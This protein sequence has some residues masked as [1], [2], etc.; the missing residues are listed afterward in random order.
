MKIRAIVVSALV[1]CSIFA[2]I[3]CIRAAQP[4]NQGRMITEAIKSENVPLL[5]KGLINKI[6]TQLEVNDDSFPSLI[7]EVET[8]TAGIQDPASVAVLHSMIAEMYNRFYS[9]DPW[10]I[11]QRTPI[12]GYIPEDIREW[13]KNLFTDKIKEELTASLQPAGLLQQTPASAFKEIL[14]SGKSSPTLRPTLFDF[15]AFRALNIQPSDTIYNELLSFRNSQPDKKAALLVD[16]D[17]LQYQFY[18]QPQAFPQSQYMH[19]LDSLLNVYGDKDYAVEILEA[20][21]NLLQQSNSRFSNPDSIKAIEYAI[22]T[23][24]I[25]RYPRYDRIG[26]LKNGL[27]ELQNPTL[28]V[29]A[30]QN[31]YPGGNLTLA[32]KYQNSSKITVS[33]YK[34]LNTTTQVLTIKAPEGNKSTLGALVKEFTFSLPLP[35]A[36]TTQDTTLQI[37]MESL[38]LYECVI[39]AHN[40]KIHTS[41][42]FSVSRLATLSR[43]M[44]S[45]NIEILVTDVQS[46]KPIDDASIVYYGG[47][48]PNQQKLGT[49]KTDK[50]GLAVLPPQKNMIAYKVTK[51]RDTFSILS[52]VFP[53]GTARPGPDDK[54]KVS[55]FTDRGIYRP[56]QTVFFKGIAYINEEDNPHVVE[57]KAYTVSLQD[58]NGQEVAK[59]QLTTNAFGSFNGEFTIPRQTLSGSFTIK[60]KGANA[61]IQVEE[62]KRPTFQVELLPLK[63][64]VTFGDLVTI[65]GKAQTFSGVALQTGNVTYRIVR[66]PFWFRM[67]AGP[68]SREQVAEGNT[69]VNQHGLFSFDFRPEKETGRG[70]FSSYQNYQVIATLTDSKG[71]TQEARYSFSVGEASII[72]STDLQPRMDKDSVNAIVTARTLNN[73]SVSVNGNYMIYTLLDTKK[74]G[75]YKEGNL[76]ANGTFTSGE[77]INQSIFSQLPSGRYR[78]KLEAKDTK[79]RLAKNEQDFILYS[80]RDKRPPVFSHTWFLQDRITCQPGEEAE[81]MFGT[82][83]KK[84]YILYELFANNECVSRKRIELSD[85]NRTFRVPFL[86]S[87]GNGVVASFIFVKE[88][89][90]YR[91][92]IHILKQQPDRTLTI[93]PETFRDRLLPGSSE[94]WKFRITKADSIPA[95]AEVLA[96]MYDAS[97][98]QILPFKWYFSPF[99]TIYLR[100]PSFSNNAGFNTSDQ[101]DALEADFVKV[102][103]YQYDRLIFLISNALN[104]NVQGIAASGRNGNFWIRGLATMRSKAA[105]AL[106]TDENVVMEESLV[107]SQDKTMSSAPAGSVKRVQQA[108]EGLNNTQDTRQQLRENF[109]ETAFFFPSLLTD[110]EGS[111]SI[112]FTLPESNTTWKFQ[113]LAHTADLKYGMLTKDII[114]SKP[115]MVLPNL[116]RFMRQGDEVSISTQVINQSKNTLTGRVSLELFDPAT[117]QPVICLTKSQ[118]PFTLATDST[119]TVYWTFT[120]PASIDLI[121]CRII[122]TSDNGSDGEQLLIPVLSNKILVTE[123]TPFYLMEQGEQKIQIPGNTASATRTPFSMTLELTSNP[124]WYAVQALPTLTEPENQNIISWF[125]SYYSNTLANHIATANPRIQKVISQWKAQGGTASTLYSNL[126]KNEELKNILLQETPWVLEANN[127]TEQKER[128]SLLFDLNRA[129]QQR[130]AA[131]QQLL[132]QQNEDGGWSWFKGLP[133]NR[134]MTLYILKGMTQLV[135][136]NAIQYGQKEKEMQIKALNYLDKQ[137]QQEYENVKKYDKNWQNSSITSSQLEYLFVRSSYRDIPELGS[138]REAIRFYTAKAEKQWDKQSL[139]GK[140]ETALLMFRNGKKEV[141]NSI[142]A[143]LRKTVT[144][145]TEKGMYWANNRKE[146]NFFTS[147]I[148][149]HCLLMAVFNE[150]AP[151]Q[152]EADR[153]KQWLLNQKRTQ[154]WESVPSTVNAI[155]ALLLTGSDW[156]SQNNTCIVQWGGQTFNSNSGEAA[157][158]Y[159]KEVVR[160]KE[161]TPEMSTITVR[162]EGNAPAWGAVYN[163]Y[164]ESITQVTG[165]KGVL[166]VEKKLFV[167][168]NNGTEQQIRPVTA[169]QPLRIGDKVIVRL[170][171]RSEQEMDYVYLKDLRAGCFEQAN[172][173]SGSTYNGGLWY[174]QSPEDVSENFFFSRLPQGTFVLEYPVYVSRQGEYAGGISTIQCLYAPEFVSHTEGHKLIVQP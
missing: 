115:L 11:D 47:Q 133:G 70:D 82:S 169:G 90:S 152:K 75:E 147:P 153:M 99:P 65:Q 28:S 24:G 174:Y 2:A 144:V 103:E 148:D 156:L 16:L 164:F 127:E 48:Y 130:E 64:E 93:K 60:T 145:S 83:D 163:Q 53:R 149:T 10:K 120:V 43:N 170:T 85:E 55:L 126:Q 74:E 72:L 14:Q 118:K 108:E 13:S 151:N 61:Y 172:Q 96:S 91:T 18:H 146:S 154:N 17:Y 12:I 71:E 100:A 155:Y 39:T 77:A 26:L 46:G 111:V 54:T 105:G 3:L 142:L 23:E 62:Y 165:Q 119:T 132:Q 87:Y 56:G 21:L 113:A 68:Q 33:I 107:V 73:E 136:L 7:K 45:G 6:Q 125:A 143:W 36:Y 89:K 27:A 137:I 79:G 162:K 140:G 32:L 124:I 171:I 20:K 135:E 123:S 160:G 15:L 19:L 94:T 5:I 59:R 67:Y 9:S 112:Q 29:Q 131:L 114:S 129:A 168:T 157:T 106:T 159:I 1:L 104:G 122:A 35:N 51:D 31:V 8:F 78:I 97:L 41:N 81:I 44:P 158:G 42:I 117:D 166:N 40:K 134:E 150:L 88:G 80:K 102:P 50:D 167:E 138:A 57:G 22:C 116:P 37:P 109:N 34:S 128:L 25:A 76:V 110:K 52:R 4:H 92:E 86:K 66:Q 98:D 38:G 49:A 69:A 95:L 101:Y 141:A 84:A 58:V 30:S 161:I 173:I 139:Y 63:E 121:G